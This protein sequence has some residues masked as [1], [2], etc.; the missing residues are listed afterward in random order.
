MVEFYE[1]V[2]YLPEA[3]VNYLAL[4]GWSLDD[5][6]EHF[7]RQQ[8]IES[9]SLE[10]V[11][12]AAASFDPKKL[13]AFEDRHFQALPLERKVALVLPFLETAGLVASP[14]PSGRGAGGE[15]VV[16]G[17]VSREARPHPRR[18]GRSDQGL[19]RHPGLRRF[20]LLRRRRS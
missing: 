12:K 11:T 5:K 10:R 15:G 9:F 6:S 14:S 17:A 1:S 16:P 13:W 2:G 7:S 4:L 8:L 3:I 18:L 20:L 19:R